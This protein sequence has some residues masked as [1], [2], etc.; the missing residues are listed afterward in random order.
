MGVQDDNGV[1]LVEVGHECVEG[2]VAEVLPVAVR[3]QFDAVGT[4]HFE[5]IACLLEGVRHIGQGQCGA[6]QET[7]WVACLQRGTLLVVSAAHRCRGLRIAE[8]R[9]WRGHG[10]HSGLDAGLVHKGNV[11]LCIPARDGKTL[12]HLGT[13]GLNVVEVALRDDVAVKVDLCNRRQC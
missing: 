8:E 7:A 10:E 11:S 13:V 3:G 5:G 12:V 9:L 4:Q 2:G 1:L 6:E